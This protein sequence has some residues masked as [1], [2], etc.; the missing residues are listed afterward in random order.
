M[1]LDRIAA[2][3]QSSSLHARQPP[4]FKECPRHAASASQNDDLKV[5]K[6]SRQWWTET[7][8]HLKALRASLVR[9]KILPPLLHVGG[10]DKLQNMKIVASRENIKID[11]FVAKN[12]GDVNRGGEKVQ[13]FPKLRLSRPKPKKAQIRVPVAVTI[14]EFPRK[15]DYF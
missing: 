4:P 9:Q 11:E 6:Q 2:P 15:D 3:T 14:L 7:T 12:R 5:H 1:Q 13:V 8:H 10:E